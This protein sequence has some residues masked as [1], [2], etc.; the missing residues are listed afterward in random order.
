MICG[1]G[2][3]GWGEAA[4]VEGWKA[5]KFCMHF[6]GRVTSW[7]W[8]IKKRMTPR[9]LASVRKMELP[10]TERETVGRTSFCFSEWEV[11]MQFQ[12]KLQPWL[13]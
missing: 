4:A 10:L 1:S 6:Q 13:V 3:D 5:F 12:M 8:G 11:K 2:E 9:F 7:M